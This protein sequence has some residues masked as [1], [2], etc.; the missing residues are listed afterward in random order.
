MKSSR[1]QS[2]KDP[3]VG[4][5]NLPRSNMIWDHHV[6]AAERD[7]PIQYESKARQLALKT[8]Y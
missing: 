2:I 6:K 4:A 1:I 3:T 7:A 5:S 8:P